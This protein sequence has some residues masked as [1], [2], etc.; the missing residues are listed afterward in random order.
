MWVNINIDRRDS[1]NIQFQW[2]KR[3][4]ADYN[5]YNYNILINKIWG[6]KWKNLNNISIFHLIE[7]FFFFHIRIIG[8]LKAAFFRFKASKFDMIF[9]LLF[10]SHSTNNN[11]LPFFFIWSSDHNACKVYFVPNA[12][13]TNRTALKSFSPR[14][15][16]L[17]LA[18]G[19]ISVFLLIFMLHLIKSNACAVHIWNFNC[20]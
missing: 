18:A 10:H 3:K 14:A 11:V 12:Q 9:N 20:E 7:F 5:L 13:W 6:K 1:K 19:S 15:N 4:R 8:E 17:L 16:A 2:W